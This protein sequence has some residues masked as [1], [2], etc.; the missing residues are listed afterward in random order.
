MPHTKKTTTKKSEPRFSVLAMMLA[1]KMRCG[2]FVGS[3]AAYESAIGRLE[4]QAESIAMSIGPV[5]PARA[6]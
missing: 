6:R 2:Q 4:R 1:E 3:Q 5:I